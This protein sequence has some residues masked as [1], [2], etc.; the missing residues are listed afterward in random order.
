VRLTAPLY[1][2]KYR[3]MKTSE[4]V[5]AL[6][7]LAHESRLS[8]FRL[9][10]QAGPQG[11]AAGTLSD[12]LGM[13]SPTLS[14]HLKELAAAR[15][16]TPKRQGRFILYSANFPQMAA[17]LSYLTQN[18]CQGMPHECLTVVETALASCGLGD[19]CNG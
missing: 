7:A 4:A 2:D 3:I 1:F 5:A 6:S 9:L 15:L 19:S 18:C 17:L 10:M 14:F 8:V 11:L 12:T 13:P 16:V